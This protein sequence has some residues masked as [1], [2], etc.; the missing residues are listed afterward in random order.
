MGRISFLFVLLFAISCQTTAPTPIQI[1]TLVE[2]NNK[3][4]SLYLSCTDGANYAP[5]KKGCDPAALE[6]SVKDTMSF[7]KIF[8]SGDIKQP[9]GYDIYL[10]TA[11]IYFRIGERN[12]REYTEAEKIARQF[13]ETQKASSGRSL[14]L[15]RFYWAA[16][17]AGHAAWQWQYDR[18]SLSSAGVVDNSVDRKTEL[19]LILSEGRT[20]LISEILDGPRKVRLTDYLEVLSFITKSVD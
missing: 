12:T 2:K 1:S 6:L 11:L 16:T 13:F 18:L 3:T 4:V 20:A 15:A 7:A 9:P 19:L 5:L 17:T 14:D 8:I 10:A